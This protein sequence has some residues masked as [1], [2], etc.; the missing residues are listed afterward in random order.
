MISAHTG[1][2]AI[3]SPFVS[4]LYM[5][6]FATITK[7]IQRILGLH[8]SITFRV[9][10]AATN[11]VRNKILLQIFRITSICN[12]LLRHL[13]FTIHTVLYEVISGVNKNKRRK[14][15]EKIVMHNTLLFAYNIIDV[16]TLALF[17]Q[18]Q[19][20]ARTCT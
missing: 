1:Q 3:C 6:Y 7:V 19:R 20:P 13:Q 10:H 9:G 18:Q 4:A 2:S 5:R 15:F 17:V 8:C 11:D 14:T 16:L 12:H